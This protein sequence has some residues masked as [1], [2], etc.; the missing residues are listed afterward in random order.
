MASRGLLMIA[1]LTKRFS[2]NPAAAGR[3]EPT[4]AS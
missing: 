4:R 3:G 2:P 1:P